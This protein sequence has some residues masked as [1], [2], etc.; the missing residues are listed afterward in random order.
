MSYPYNEIE[1]KLC[2]IA[3]ADWN[4]Q[5]ISADG[6]VKDRSFF[7]RLFKIFGLDQLPWVKNVLFNANLTDASITVK[8]LLADSRNETSAL[9]DKI[10]TALYEKVETKFNDLVKHRN[11]KTKSNEV[12]IYIDLKK[13]FPEQQ[14]ILESLKR[15]LLPPEPTETNVPVKESEPEQDEIMTVLDAQNWSILKDI[16]REQEQTTAVPV[17]QEPVVVTED[18][19]EQQQTTIPVEE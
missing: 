1:T 5:Y 4:T 17:E 11:A 16:I 10:K 2:R 3:G 12:S 15:N 7:G 19:P 18:A 13:L 8:R 9:D 6:S 14:A